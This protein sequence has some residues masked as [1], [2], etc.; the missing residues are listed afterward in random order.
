MKKRAGRRRAGKQDVRERTASGLRRL[1]QGVEKLP[2]AAEP[3][4][5]LFEPTV[6]PRRG[7]NGWV[8]SRGAL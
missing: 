3:A 6:W 7:R 4:R 2:P 1:E 8:G 5:E